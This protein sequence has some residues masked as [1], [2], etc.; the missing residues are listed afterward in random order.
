MLSDTS[1]K[2]LLNQPKLEDS[3][4]GVRAYLKKVLDKNE[5]V[6]RFHQFLPQLLAR[7]IGS[8]N[9]GYGRARGSAFSRADALV[10]L[11]AAGSTRRGR[12]PS[13]TPSTSC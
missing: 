6:R 9:K 13:R 8:D 3:I 11:K 10:L 12:T 4:A 5:D 2:G 1:L 7:I